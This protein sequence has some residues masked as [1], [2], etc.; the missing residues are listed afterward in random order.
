MSKLKR[1]ST[2]LEKLI[3]TDVQHTSGLIKDAIKTGWK[4]G[5]MQAAVDNKNLV[6]DMYTRTK[7]ITKEVKKLR[8]TKDDIP[9]IAAVVGNFIPLPIPGL[10]ILTYFA[11][12]GIKKSI[13]I[14]SKIHK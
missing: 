8:F 2:Q 14:Y 9:A 1:I 6:Q 5:K 10:S 7:D 3:P 4:N 13:E 12:K 11:G